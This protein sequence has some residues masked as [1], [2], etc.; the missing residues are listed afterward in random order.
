MIKFD[1]VTKENMTQ[2][3][4]NWP[5]RDHL[6]RM[7]IIWSSGSGKTKSLFNLISYQ[8]KI[9]KIYLHVKG[10]YKAKYQLF[11]KKQE[12]TV[13]K[14]LMISKLLLNTQMIWMIFTKIL[15]NAIWIKKIKILFVFDDLI[16]D[17]LK[18][19]IQ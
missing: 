9:D 16:A 3:N 11:I 1:N 12:S 8:P 10:L 6:H 14:H 5:V 18:N 19:L 15:K 4:P 2:H 17:M 13:L 7:L